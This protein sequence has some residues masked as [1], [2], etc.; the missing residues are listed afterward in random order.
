MEFV[1]D[2]FVCVCLKICDCYFYILHY[3]F[4]YCRVWI[5]NTA[6]KWL[7]DAELINYSCN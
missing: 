2:A 4:V 1:R 6:G 5:E 7:R 3:I